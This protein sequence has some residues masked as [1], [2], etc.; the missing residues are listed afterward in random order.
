[1]T[2]TLLPIRKF[3]FLSIIMMLSG[4]LLSVE[5]HVDKKNPAA[6]DENP[7][8][9]EKP[10]RHIQPAADKVQPGDTITIHG[11]TYREPINWKTAG[12]KDKMITVQSAPGE[13]VAIK[14]SVLVKGW[15]KISARD[16]GL[17]GKFPR[18]NIWAKKDWE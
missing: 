10:F 7:G 2:T 17:K 11:G 9:A 3:L 4:T 14:G 15:E 12:T 1:M 5:Y 18:E 16:A 6:S 8:T 13:I